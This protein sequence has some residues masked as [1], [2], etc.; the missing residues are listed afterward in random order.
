[1][2]SKM[3]TSIPKELA[4]PK[5]QEYYDYTLNQAKRL[6]KLISPGSRYTQRSSD[7]CKATGEM[8]I[9]LTEFAGQVRESGSGSDSDNGPL[10]DA[11]D[12]FGETM[13][14]VAEGNTENML[15]EEALLVSNMQENVLLLNGSSRLFEARKGALKTFCGVKDGK[16]EGMDLEEAEKNFQKF[17]DAMQP[18]LELA[19]AAVE[20]DLTNLLFTMVQLRK[21]ALVKELQQWEE[22]EEKLGSM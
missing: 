6:D 18:E 17:D 11:F 4:Q 2:K 19:N 12:A 15:D 10:A 3:T 5:C 1:M 16:L 8:G 9:A 14:A 22:L 20:E 21:A 13:Q 7:Y